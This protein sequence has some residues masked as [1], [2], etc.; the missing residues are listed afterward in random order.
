MPLPKFE[1]VVKHIFA[2]EELSNRKLNLINMGAE[3]VVFEVEGVPDK[4]F[5]IPI[6]AFNYRTAS[7]IQ[8][9]DIDKKECDRQVI[10]GQMVYW[11]DE[12]ELEEEAKMI[13]GKEHFLDR[14]IFRVTIPLT[15][16]MLVKYWGEEKT[17]LIPDDFYE[18]VKM[19]AE[20]QDAL[21]ALTNPSDYYNI[22]F[23][24]Y[25]VKGKDF[26]SSYDKS[27][28]QFTAVVKTK[29]DE[30]LEMMKDFILDEYLG[31]V[32]KKIVTD[33]T[34]Y[35]KKTGRMMDLFGKD[36]LIIFAKKEQDLSSEITNYD[37][38]FIEFSMVG[39]K[40]DFMIKFEEDKNSG[41]KLLPYYYS[42]YYFIHKLAEKFGIEDNL[43]LEDLYYFQNS[44]VVNVVK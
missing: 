33:I 34:R 2:S 35:T 30:Q 9:T 39:D 32:L 38:M 1:E 12:M 40:D 42:Y 26:T 28:E 44:E 10:E 21:D 14:G 7:I 8:G 24:I 43:K 3:K 41:N 31:P 20:S 18:E 27:V 19:L 23:G 25:L 11:E 36:N 22:P 17:K 5:K 37:Y 16:T 15:K 6:S 4:V 29:I 13:F